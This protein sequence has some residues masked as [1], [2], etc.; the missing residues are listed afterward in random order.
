MAVAIIST[1][2]FDGPFQSVAD[3]QAVFGLGNQALEPVF[4]DW[5]GYL[6]D[7]CL[8]VTEVSPSTTLVASPP[9]PTPASPTPALPNT[10]VETGGLVLAAVSLIGLGARLVRKGT[11]A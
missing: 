4:P 7:A 2:S 5:P 9:P 11:D 10:G 8:T 1:T 3:L 6:S